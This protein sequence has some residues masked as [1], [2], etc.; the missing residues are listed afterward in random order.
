MDNLRGALLMILAMAGFA[1]ED[2]LIKLL[3]AH[4]PTGQVI[5]SIGFFGAPVFALWCLMR[6]LPL[7]TPRFWHPAIVL[8][9]GS[10]ALGTL[11]FVTSLTLVPLSLASAIL[12]AAPLLV[13]LGAALFLGEQ[14]GWR[15]WSAIGAGL[16]GVL[17]ILRPGTGDF[18]PAA[19]L[20][21]A[22]TC[23]LA[24]RDVATRRVPADIRSPQLSW[25]A[26]V[27]LVPTGLILLTLGNQ[28][29]GALIGPATLP[30]MATVA[31]GV[32]AYALIVA[33]TRTGDVGFV[34]PF[35][36][37]RLVFSLVLGI[38]VLGESPDLLTLIGAVIVIGMGLYTFLR[39]RRLAR[40]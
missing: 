25:L 4:W 22:G 26:F 37:S 30:F 17:L 14:V 15:R 12:Q 27:I 7:V 5:A 39:E 34:T 33:A 8:R 36:Y 29:P 9:N 40:A 1:V 28:T 2:A 21:F 11:L 32:I 6:G 3:S 35:R 19:L 16:V 24:A 20:A 23:G 13:T 18:E 38:V 31:I 10:E